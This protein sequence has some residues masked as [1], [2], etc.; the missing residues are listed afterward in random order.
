MT[1]YEEILDLHYD[2]YDPQ[3]IAKLLHLPQDEIEEIIAEHEME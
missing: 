3:E 2:G 1:D